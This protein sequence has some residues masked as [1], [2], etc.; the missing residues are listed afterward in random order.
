MG[1]NY[2]KEGRLDRTN[3]R[4]KYSCNIYRDNYKY[5]P[6]KG[7]IYKDKKD[8]V[9]HFI[10]GERILT[11]VLEGDRNAKKIENSNDDLKRGKYKVTKKNVHG[12]RQQWRG[13][14]ASQQ[15]TV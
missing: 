5:I 3:I 14:L 11:T 8:V 4:G 2:K 7:Y 10:N 1:F 12:R 6:V 9:E 13:R 15:N